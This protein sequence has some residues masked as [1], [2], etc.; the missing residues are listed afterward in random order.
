L[1]FTLTT[2]DE[3]GAGAQLEVVVGGVVVVVDADVLAVADT[4]LLEALFAAS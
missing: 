1:S 3:V 2:T 4:E